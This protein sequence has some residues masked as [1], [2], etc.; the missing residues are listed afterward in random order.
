MHSIDC[1]DDCDLWK[2]GIFS[3]VPRYLCVSRRYPSHGVS[4]IY[5]KKIAFL[6]FF[7]LRFY[8]YCISSIIQMYINYQICKPIC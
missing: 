4:K 6:Y 3:K 5:G 7:L 8:N 1:N 2:D